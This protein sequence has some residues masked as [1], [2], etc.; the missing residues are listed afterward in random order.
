M[1]LRY[2]YVKLR[3][4]TFITLRYVTLVEITLNYVKLDAPHTSLSIATALEHHLKHAVGVVSCSVL[5][6]P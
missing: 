6:I 5:S 2:N 4:I 1:K 3:Y